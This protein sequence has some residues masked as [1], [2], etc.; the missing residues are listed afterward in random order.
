MLYKKVHAYQYITFGVDNL[1]K[2]IHAWLS[3]MKKY[4]YAIIPATNSQNINAR[5]K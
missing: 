1:V 4:T 2:S 3:N 5:I